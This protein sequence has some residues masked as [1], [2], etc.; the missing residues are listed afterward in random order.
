MEKKS[1]LPYTF[2]DFL[3]TFLVLT[4]GGWI[5]LAI[6]I[7]AT[8]PTLGPRWLFFFMGVIALSGTML[9]VTYFLN[10]RFPSTPPA[11]KYVIIRQAIW[12]GIYG[13]SL[14]WLQMGHVLNSSL[15][16][17]LA[18]AFIVIELLIRVWERSRWKPD[19]TE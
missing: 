2:K 1:P 8:L 19:Q 9:P 5:G 3:V 16:F 10:R 7:F 13:S 4:L 18:G 17:I 12:F 15:A 14:A 11:D 6:V